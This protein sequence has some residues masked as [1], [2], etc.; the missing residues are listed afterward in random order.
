[1]ERRY[2]RSWSLLR[3]PCSA[4]RPLTTARGRI[5]LRFMNASRSSAA[6]VARRSRN[7]CMSSQTRSASLLLN[8]RL[9][10]E[11]ELRRDGIGRREGSCVASLFAKVDDVLDERPRDAA[12]D[13]RLACVPIARN[14][15]LADCPCR[16]AFADA[17]KGER[18]QRPRAC[19]HHLVELR[20]SIQERA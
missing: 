2:G 14:E 5:P 1:M 20:L 19:V 3:S 9:D 15:F 12:P 13:L 6:A 7:V 8:A 18:A 16:S 4:M 10:V 11:R 17:T